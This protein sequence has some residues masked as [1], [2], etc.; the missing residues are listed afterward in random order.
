[1]IHRLEQSSTV[2]RALAQE[3][4]YDE[5]SGIPNKIFTVDFFL[6]IVQWIADHFFYRKRKKLSAYQIFIKFIYFLL[7]KFNA[8]QDN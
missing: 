3:V 4:I 5:A 8:K 2:C 7:I 6:N 1:M